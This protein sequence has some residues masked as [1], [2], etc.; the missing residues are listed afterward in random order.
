[1][2]TALV[3]LVAAAT[4]GSVVASSRAAHATPPD[5]ALLAKLAQDE[6][7]IEATAKRASY[8][9]EQVIEQLDGDGKVASTKTERYRVESDGT[10]R[11]RIVESAVE[12]GKD[13]TAKEQEEARSKEA[14][15][16]SSKKPPPVFPFAPGSAARYEYDQVAVSP[17]RPELVEIAFKPKSPDSETF[18]GKVWVDA[19]SG[20]ILSASVRLSKPPMLVDWVHLTAEFSATAAG[21]ALSHLTFEGSGGLLFI[22]KHFRGHVSTSDWRAA[23]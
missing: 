5:A 17:T 7:A 12:D 10:T 11:H 23:P 3:A 1:M 16:A 8:R 18:E 21:P 4:A 9:G 20:K 15:R 13:V 6:Q 14:E 22:H 2:K 19:A